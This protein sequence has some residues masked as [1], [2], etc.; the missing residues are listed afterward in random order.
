MNQQTITHV[1]AGQPVTVHCI[2]GQGAL[3][4]DVFETLAKLSQTE[5]LRAGLKIRFGWSSLTLCE[6]VQA[7]LTV[8]EP[9][10][11]GNP[12]EQNR[13]SLGVTLG[14][15]AEQAAILKRVSV[16]PVEVTFDQFIVLRKEAL[17][18]T[19]IVLSRGPSTSA[20]DS[21]WSIDCPD[22]P[23]GPER[24]ED[25]EAKRVYELLKT[26]PAILPVLILPVGYLVEFQGNLITEVLDETGQ[27]RLIG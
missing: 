26:R 12:F 6:G 2:A 9:D 27:D 13:P 1:I 19:T 20:D 15:L 22:Q 24:E 23:S 17:S 11:D 10:F 18:S 16:D 14:V 8:C 3:A 4:A 7:G 21:G 25:Y 5:P